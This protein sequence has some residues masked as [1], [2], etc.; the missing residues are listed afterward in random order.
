MDVACLFKCCFAGSLHNQIHIGGVC[1]L[2]L[3]SSD[4]LYS[5]NQPH[6]LDPVDGI[7]IYRPP[8]D[9]AHHVRRPP[10]AP[11]PCVLCSIHGLQRAELISCTKFVEKQLVHCEASSGGT[12]L[13]EGARASAWPFCLSINAHLHGSLQGNLRNLHS[14]KFSGLAN[15]KVRNLGETRGR[16]SD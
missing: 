1:Y 16:R 9:L 3:L 8:Q 7:Q 4:R 13:L 6:E 5:C 2:C 12:Y 11:Y 15:N 14:Q 10:M